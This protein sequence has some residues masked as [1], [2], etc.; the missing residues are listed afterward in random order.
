[1]VKEAVKTI[2][3]CRPHFTTWKIQRGLQKATRINKFTFR[4]LLGCK[5][6]LLKIVF[7]YYQRTIG[8]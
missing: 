6:N 5:S 3:I 4:K 1:M 8:N 2:V 7:I